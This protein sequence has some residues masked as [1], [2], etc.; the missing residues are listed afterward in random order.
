[1]Q[2]WWEKHGNKK[3]QKTQEEDLG[4]NTSRLSVYSQTQH[5]LHKKPSFKIK[6]HTSEDQ[7]HIVWNTL[8]LVTNLI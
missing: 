7:N 5:P 6:L 4:W 1:M 2:K 3:I 8:S